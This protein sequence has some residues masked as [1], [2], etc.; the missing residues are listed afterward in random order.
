MSDHGNILLIDS[1]EEYIEEL[2]SITQV[3]NKFTGERVTKPILNKYEKAK[4]LG[5]RAMQISRNA[6]IFVEIN[7][8]DID[9]LS[10]A[11]KELNEKKTP[12]IIRR[13]L[14]DDRYEDWHISELDIT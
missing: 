6:P 11:E 4:V 9:A 8:N 5:T 12:I 10:I 2:E 3:S 14:P 1:E 7:E 13:Y